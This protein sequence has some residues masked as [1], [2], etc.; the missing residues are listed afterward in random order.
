MELFA[1][2]QVKLDQ[3]FGMKRYMCVLVSM[4]QLLYTH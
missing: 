2:E 4:A 1:I 3:Y